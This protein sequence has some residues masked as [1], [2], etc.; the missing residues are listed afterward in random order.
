MTTFK[1]F[2]STYCSEKTSI[3]GSNLVEKIVEET[4]K[5]QRLK[6]MSFRWNDSIR[7]YPKPMMQ[8]ILCGVNEA[9]LK[10]IEKEQTEPELKA[11]LKMP[12]EKS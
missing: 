5:S 7:G 4:M 10:V 11:L 1:E 3:I 12:F 6:S 9:A 8:I 2:I